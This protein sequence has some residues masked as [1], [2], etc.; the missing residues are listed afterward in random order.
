MKTLVVSLLLIAIAI[1][2]AF[3]IHQDAGLVSVEFQ[4]INRETTL[5]IALAAIGVGFVGFYIVARFLLGL[6]NAPKTIKKRGQ[7][8]RER[9]S[10][11]GL[12]NGLIQIEE[13]NF[14]AAESAMLANMSANKTCDAATY[15]TAA[16]CANARDQVELS[17]SYL[18]KAVQSSPYA[19]LSAGIA[20]A[21]MLLQRHEYRDA[22]KK[23]SELRSKEPANPRVMWLL[24]QAYE[25][26]HNWESMVE[27]LRS[28]RK[29]KAAPVNQIVKMESLAAV[30]ALKDAADGNV[31]AIFD[32]QPSH[33]QSLA[34]VVKAYASRLNDM[35]QVDDAAKAVSKALNSEWNDDL[36][37]LYG[38]IESSDASAQL[39]QAEKWSAANGES[40]SLLLSLGNLSYRRSLWGKAKEY[41]VKSIGIRPTQ[42]AF[43]AL[44]KTLEAMDDNSAALEAYK[45]GYA[46]NEEATA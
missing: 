43:F 46:V 28:V 44:G 27:L 11:E 35:G 37:G 12:S 15:I 17:D 23:L 45:H 39:E 25:K 16:K 18:S 9:K 26:V 13:G 2:T 3:F 24:V 8:N 7:L 4:G 14:E 41:V 34:E 29:K 38:E 21:E 40:V 5:G 22:V 20:S 32:N 33:V 6:L 10:H 31:Q 36:A 30:G 42:E 19:T 1:A